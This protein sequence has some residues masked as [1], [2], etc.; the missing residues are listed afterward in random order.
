M[1]CS[2]AQ[3]SAV[4]AGRAAVVFGGG[5]RCVCAWPCPCASLLPCPQS[6]QLHAPLC[7]RAHCA[8]PV[9]HKPRARV[10]RWLRALARTCC[11]PPPAGSTARTLHCRLT[12]PPTPSAPARTFTRVVF[13]VL[14]PGGPERWRVLSITTGGRHSMCLAQ[15]MRDAHSSQASIASASDQQWLEEGDEDEELGSEASLFGRWAG[16]PCTSMQVSRTH[17]PCPA[18]SH[19]HPTLLCAGAH[20]PSPSPR[21]SLCREVGELT[22]AAHAPQPS[23]LQQGPA[24]S[25]GAAPTPHALTSAALLPH[26]TASH[27]HSP[28]TPSAT[29]AAAHPPPPPPPPPAPAAAGAATGAGT[30]TE[31]SGAA[32]G[33]GWVSRRR[34][35]SGSRG[36]SIREA[37]NRGRVQVHGDSGRS[38]G[39][40][41]K[42]HS[43]LLSFHSR[44][45]AW[46]GGLKCSCVRGAGHLSYT[47]CIPPLPLSRIHIHTYANTHTPTHTH[48]RTGTYTHTHTHTH[49]TAHPH[50]GS[51]GTLS[52]S[53]HTSPRGNVSPFH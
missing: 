52:P 2:T 44:A 39:E 34:S 37:S 6:T 4:L 13:V 27:P 5:V 49:T 53:R 28:P 21:P 1:L 8:C 14:R 40:A 47:V 33:A 35:S 32:E 16:G 22:L 46:C 10:C 15:P 12:A 31:G 36:G 29:A 9:L 41:G 7:T 38:S 3:H 30:S 45:G 43:H 20:P 17:T 42:E 23:E 48:T 51:G 50:A 18:A 24:P 26:T 19:T 25:A 11:P